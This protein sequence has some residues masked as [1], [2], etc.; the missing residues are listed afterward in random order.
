[1]ATLLMIFFA[2][3]C[4]DFA[5]KINDVIFTILDESATRSSQ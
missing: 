3:F 2:Q 1:M 4:R 5:T